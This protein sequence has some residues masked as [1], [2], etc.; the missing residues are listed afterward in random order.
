LLR[1]HEWAANAELRT[2]KAVWPLHAAIFFS[3]EPCVALLLRHGA[4]ADAKDCTGRS[5]LQAARTL[6]R[7]AVVA[8]LEADATAR[9]VLAA[10]SGRRRLTRRL[11]PFC[12]AQTRAARLARLDAEIDAA[13]VCAAAL[14]KRCRG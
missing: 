10:S 9:R 6:K 7:D 2:T 13:E 8:L 11:C 5:A 1:D 4:D 3:H 12:A 14:R